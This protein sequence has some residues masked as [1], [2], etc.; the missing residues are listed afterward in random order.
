M[1]TDLDFFNTPPD[2]VIGRVT[3]SVGISLYNAVNGNRSNKT[4]F[5]LKHGGVPILLKHSILQT[6]QQSML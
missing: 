1:Y 3:E 5:D 6:P 2:V 4:E